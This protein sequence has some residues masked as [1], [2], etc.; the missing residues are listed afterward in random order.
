VAWKHGKKQDMNWLKT[1]N[2]LLI[3][4]LLVF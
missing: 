4:V 2:K 1:K 3:G